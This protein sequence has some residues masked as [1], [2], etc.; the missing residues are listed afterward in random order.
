MKIGKNLILIFF[1]FQNILCFTSLSEFASKLKS[2]VDEQLKSASDLSI[3]DVLNINPSSQLWSNYL[4]LR[5]GEN[6]ITDQTS[7]TNR[8]ALSQRSSS[9]AANEISDSLSSS[10]FDDQYSGVMNMAYAEHKLK[11]LE[12]NFDQISMAHSIDEQIIQNCVDLYR[13][14][15]VKT[16]AYMNLLFEEI[17]GYLIKLIGCQNE[18]FNE[19]ENKKGIKMNKALMQENIQS[20]NKSIA[21]LRK[22]V[23]CLVTTSGMISALKQVKYDCLHRP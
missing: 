15:F 17:S 11:V 12:S 7:L 10:S 20:L 9:F 18:L 1:Y 21:S 19:L 3:D 8:N 13:E 22:T 23:I 2:N 14:K 6:S 5:K 4:T 16:D